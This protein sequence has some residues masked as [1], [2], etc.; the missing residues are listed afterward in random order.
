[1]SEMVF[2]RPLCQINAFLEDCEIDKVEFY[3]ADEGASSARLGDLTK[4]IIELELKTSF[5]GFQIFL[6]CYLTNPL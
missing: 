2:R 6:F 1:M 4:L 5:F 3:V